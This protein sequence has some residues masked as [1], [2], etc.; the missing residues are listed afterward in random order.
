MITVLSGLEVAVEVSA[1]R[2]G[3]EECAVLLGAG[4]SKYW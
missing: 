3:G 2:I 4:T 1:L